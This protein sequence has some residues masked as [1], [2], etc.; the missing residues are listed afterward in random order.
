[1]TFS[2]HPFPSLKNKIY[3]TLSYDSCEKRIDK[4]MRQPVL[5]LN[6]QQNFCYFFEKQKPKGMPRAGY[7]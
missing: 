3:N 4:W 5:I 7:H 2:E 6:V 1:M